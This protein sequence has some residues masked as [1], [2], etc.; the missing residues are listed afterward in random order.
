MKVTLL[1]YTK[2]PERMIATA[3]RICYDKTGSFEEINNSFTDEKIEK[4]LN[5]MLTMSQHGTVLEH[6]VFTF[7]IEGIS[8][9]SSHQL[10]RHRMQSVDQRSQRY[11]TED[12]F[13]WVIPPSIANNKEAECGFNLI[14]DTIQEAYNKLITEYNIPKEDARALL[15]NAC[16]TSLIVTMNIRSL[17]HFFNLRCC[18]RC[19]SEL[20]TV[21]NEMLKLCKEVS[22]IIFKNAGASCVQNGFCPEGKMSCG[23]YPT[24]EELKCKN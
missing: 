19:Q 5:K 21:A 12:R 1:N 18:T 22:P 20:R 13:D 7:G 10:V 15:P 8:R 6:C 2:E 9:A 4:F 3:A 24:L 23:A 14:M 11:I 17:F 16:T